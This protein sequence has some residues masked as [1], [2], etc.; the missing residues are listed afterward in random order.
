MTKGDHIVFVVDDDVRVRD[1]L[2]ELLESHGMRAKAY[3][4]AGDYAK[5]RQPDVPRTLIL[6]VELPDIN[7]LNLQKHLQAKS[8]RRLS[9]FTRNG[10]SPSSVNAIQRGNWGLSYQAVRRP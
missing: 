8:P 2:V 6:D 9:S 10:E 5:A 4:A 7:R 3:G 1:A